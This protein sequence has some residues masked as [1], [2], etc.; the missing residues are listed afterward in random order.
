MYF[1]LSHPVWSIFFYIV[2]YKCFDFPYMLN[3]HIISTNIP[4]KVKSISIQYEKYSIL[5]LY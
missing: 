5:R 4:C 1:I 2:S 3:N